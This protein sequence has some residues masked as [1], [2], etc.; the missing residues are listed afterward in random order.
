VPT[1]DVLSDA[2]EVRLSY[3]AVALKIVRSYER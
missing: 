3:D 1:M 2:E